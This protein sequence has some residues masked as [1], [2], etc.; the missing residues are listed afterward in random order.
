MTDFIKCA[1]CDYKT[2]RWTTG[3]DGKKK[4]GW[5]RLRNHIEITHHAEYMEVYEKIAE[6]YEIKEAL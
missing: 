4:G 2:P 6:E 1:F 5:I 3:K